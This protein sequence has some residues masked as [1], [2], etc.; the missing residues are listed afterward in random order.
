[1]FPIY[2]SAIV[3]RAA[4]K[5]AT[6][7]LERGTTLGVLEQ[8][9]GSRTVATAFA[10]QLQIRSW[11]MIS[12][13]LVAIWSLSPIGGQ[14]ILHILST[15]MKASSV[16]HN[17]SYFNSRQQS[18]SSIAG[19]FK[20]QWFSGFAVLLGSAILE[21]LSVKL[22]TMDAWGNVKIP[23]Y[24]NSTL[25]ALDEPNEGWVDTLTASDFT[26]LFGIPIFGIDYGNTTF[27]VESSYIELSCT[28]MTTSP[29]PSDS[30]GQLIKTNLI[31]TQGPFV[32][33]QNASII[34]PWAVGY[35]GVD[36][37]SF[38]LNDNDTSSYI[39]PQACPD[40]LPE[41]YQNKTFDVGVLL[42]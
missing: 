6:W 13:G 19:A 34:T 29:I 39:Y 25:L 35:K 10:T 12:I 11:N 15:P 9:M 42:F 20:T 8:L 40:C 33:A 17:I 41:R 31:S 27:S 7:K 3:G 36:I 24:S 37:P 1:L 16:L 22:G 26:S 38:I 28:N 18:Y 23:F 2:F 21:P 30:T 5:Y 32:S 14:S 4:V